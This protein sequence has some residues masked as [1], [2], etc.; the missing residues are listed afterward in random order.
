MPLA[1][2]AL[3]TDWPENDEVTTTR[4]EPG[5]DHFQNKGFLTSKEHEQLTSPRLVVHG[6]VHGFEQV[7]CHR[8]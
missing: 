8:F 6:V 2:L 5:S 1:K 4:R 7:L 3:P